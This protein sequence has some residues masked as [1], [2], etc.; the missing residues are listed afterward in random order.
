M[1]AKLMLPRFARTATTELQKEVV[2]NVPV[3]GLFVAKSAHS[4][5]AI[6]AAVRFDFF[7]LKSIEIQ[8]STTIL[9]QVQTHR[10]EFRLESI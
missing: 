6:P 8:S 7:Y 9:L 5:F 10:Y 1:R 2:K 4:K 3:S